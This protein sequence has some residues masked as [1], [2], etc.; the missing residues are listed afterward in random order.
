VLARPDGFPPTRT[1]DGIGRHA[2]FEMTPGTVALPHGWGHRGGWSLANAAGGVNVN[3][4]AS[5]EPEDLE[6]LA[7]M[8]FL[9][10]DPGQPRAGWVCGAR[11]VS[12]SRRRAS[13]IAAV[14]GVVPVRSASSKISRRMSPMPRTRS[15][16]CLGS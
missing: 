13:S 1:L 4:L 16:A 8:A 9:K 14:S 2:P 7:G 15:R 12:P 3:L 5:S 10:R 6:P 11:T